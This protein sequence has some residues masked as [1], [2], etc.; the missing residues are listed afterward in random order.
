MT[1][2]LR[3]MIEDFADL[4]YRQRQPRLA[5]E[6]YVSPNYIQHNP[7]LLD[8]PESALEMLEP[9]FAREGAQ[10]EVKRIIVEAP[11]AVIH[12]HGRADAATLGGAVAD[13]YR[14]ENGKIVEHWDVLQAIPADRRNPR[15]MVA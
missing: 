11:F 7:N 6:K 3:E 12:L 15:D 2:S 13:I 4:F 8:G 10:F 5:F 9:M 14:V 1:T